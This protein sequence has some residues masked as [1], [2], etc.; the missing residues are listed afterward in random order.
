MF[1]IGREDGVLMSI[2]KGRKKKVE[3]MTF[4]DDSFSSLEDFQNYFV[5]IR[6]YFEDRIP[7]E[8]VIYNVELNTGSEWVSPAILVSY[9]IP[10]T[11]KEL[12]RDKR[13]R[14]AAKEGAKKAK[15][16]R[17]EREKKEL[18]RLKAKYPDA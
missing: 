15:E 8:G 7:R 13:R 2:P 11:P 10:K 9:H 4:Y 18:Q 1:R 3:S 6:K 16:K 17:I 14:E 12:A 5:K